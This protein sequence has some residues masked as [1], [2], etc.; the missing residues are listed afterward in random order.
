MALSAIERRLE[1]LVEG[2]F[3]LTLRSGLQPVELG[4]RLTRAMD[5]ERS[6]GVRGLIAPNHFIF[7]LSPDDTTRL[8]PI[9]PALVKDLVITARE[10]ATAE[11]YTFV[12]AV[13]VEFTVNE[14]R[15]PGSFNLNAS[16]NSSAVAAG[17][18]ALLT[19]S[20]GTSYQLNTDVT[21]TIGRLPDSSLS[22]NDPNVSRHHAE[23]AHTAEGFV[24][25]DLGSTNG[26][27]V[28]GAKITERILQHNDAITVATLTVHFEQS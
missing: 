12:G 15:K 2:A 3:G 1:K 19:A 23:I 11:G 24:I 9:F 5:A 18:P 17:P 8:K 10:H 21:F 25:R 28:N 14:K 7:D 16:A 13:A 4:R 22:L 20:N 27:I 6:V 26:T